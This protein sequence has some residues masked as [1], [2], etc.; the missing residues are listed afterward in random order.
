[1]YMHSL[2]DIVVQAGIVYLSFTASVGDITW[3]DSQ[4]VDG[5][6]CV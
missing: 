6:L 1:M 4:G 3:S 2:H 5:V